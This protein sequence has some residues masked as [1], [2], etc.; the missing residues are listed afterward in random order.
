MPYASTTTNQKVKLQ[1]EVQSRKSHKISVACRGLAVWC[2]HNFK[3]SRPSGK[4]TIAW[5]IRE[6][7][8]DIMIKWKAKMDK[9][10]QGFETEEV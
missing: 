9:Q 6:S 3:L 1:H 5:I 7:Y 10:E 8:N 4:Y 2:D